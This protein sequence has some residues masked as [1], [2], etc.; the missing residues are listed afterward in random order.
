MRKSVNSMSNMY[1]RALSERYVPS[2]P[3]SDMYAEPTEPKR[4]AAFLTA[5]EAALLLESARTFQTD[6][7]A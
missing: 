2:N 4:E 7:G 3:V 1:A 6:T 5:H